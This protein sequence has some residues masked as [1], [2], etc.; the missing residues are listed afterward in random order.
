MEGLMNRPYENK[1]RDKCL[2]LYN[3]VNPENMSLDRWQWKNETGTL[4]KSLIQT[5]WDGVRLVGF[6][7]IIPLRLYS[8]GRYLKGGLSDIAVTHP[9]YRY[10]GIFSELGKTLYR[11]AAEQGIEI[12]YGFPTEHSVQG[13]K[14]RLQWDYITAA[15]PMFCWNSGA[16]DSAG[17]EYQIR[18]TD[19]IGLEHDILWKDLAR[20]IF[21][22]CAVAI[23][24]AGYMRWRFGEEPGQDYRIFLVFKGGGPVGCAVTCRKICGGEELWEI[25]DITASETVCF[26]YLIGYL[27][28]ELAAP[29]KLKVP[30]G[31]LFH[32][33]VKGM[34]FREGG[35]SYYFGSHSLKQKNTGTEQ[36]FY[37]ICDSC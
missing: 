26:R 35:K 30:Q 1:D 2:E 6:Y 10:R 31:G 32:S 13:F 9:D 7:G 12:I 20:G 25:A 4:G 17:G 19:E 14:K 23:R 15:R 27:K 28:K 3:Y 11:R 24:D 22:K 36:W 5:S 16:K 21:S 29:I 18:E 33:L 34:G 37:T 8:G